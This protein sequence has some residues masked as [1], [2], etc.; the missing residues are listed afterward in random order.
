GLDGLDGYNLQLSTFCQNF[1]SIQSTD[2]F[3]S[4]RINF[5]LKSYFW[6]HIMERRIQLFS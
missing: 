6:G 4:T 5:S 3:L 1:K 2:Y